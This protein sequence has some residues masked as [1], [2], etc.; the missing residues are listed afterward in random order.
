MIFRLKPPASQS[1]IN[2][3]SRD[4]GSVPAITRMSVALAPAATSRTSSSLPSTGIWPSRDFSV[5]SVQRK[6][7]MR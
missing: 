5:S 2:C 7:R 3:R 4:P 6:P 1:F